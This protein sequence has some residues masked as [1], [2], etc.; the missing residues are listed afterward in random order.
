MTISITEEISMLKAGAHNPLWAPAGSDLVNAGH[1]GTNSL[2]KLSMRSLRKLNTFG[3][4]KVAECQ[5]GHNLCKVYG[6][7][8][9][10]A[11]LAPPQIS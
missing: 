9:L 4:S 2:R 1:Y 3:I 8:L 11:G 10:A 7:V 5:R 6:G